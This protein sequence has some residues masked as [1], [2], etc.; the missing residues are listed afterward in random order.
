MGT[1]KR[2]KVEGQLTPETSEI[3]RFVMEHS[4]PA[5]HFYA[6][7][8]GKG[9][10]SM[11][12]VVGKANWYI[13]LHPKVSTLSDVGAANDNLVVFLCHVRPE[14]MLTSHPIQVRAKIG[15][16]LVFHSFQVS[17]WRTRV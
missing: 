16:V 9:S 7:T 3:V 10:K 17:K 6:G 5:R 11:P 14:G 12:H 4:W 2:M 1:V 13:M 8:S 15:F